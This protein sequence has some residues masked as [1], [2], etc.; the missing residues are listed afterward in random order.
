M[1]HGTK[2]LVHNPRFTSLTLS[3]STGT[4]APVLVLH[5][6]LHLRHVP[7]RG[8]HLSVS[9]GGLV[10][11]LERVGVRLEVRPRCSGLGSSAGSAV[12]AAT[13]LQLHTFLIL[14]IAIEDH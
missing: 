3:E 14:V 6:P 12:T 1:Q 7:N 10:E 9:C 13:F 11:P 4:G 8:P 5:F 2:P